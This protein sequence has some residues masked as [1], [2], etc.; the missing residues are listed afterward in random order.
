VIDLVARLGAIP[1]MR[2]LI[3]GL[4]LPLPLPFPLRRSDAAW[5]PRP[6]DD[7]AV[8]FG[9]APGGALARVVARTLVMAGASP[10]VVASANANGASADARAF[11]ELGEAHGRPPVALDVTAPPAGFRARG[12][13]F[14]AT[15]VEDPLA[16][17][18]LHAFFHPLLPSLEASGRV[19]VLG[20]PAA[21]ALS[22]LQAAARTAL[23]GFVRSLA[24]EVGRR[25]ATAQLVVVHP[26][27]EARLEPVLRFILSPRAAFVSGQSLSV[28][29][30]V[31]VTWTTSSSSSSSSSSFDPPFV[32][33][34]EG[35]VALVTG[36]ARGIGE[37]TARCLAREGARVVCLDR[38]ADDA[39]A[40]EVAHD[41][42]GELLALDLGAADAPAAIT[43]HLRARH[44]GLDVL[45][46]NAG[47]T[48]DRTLA[49]M[50]AEQWS[51]VLDVNLMAMARV[52]GALD[53]AGL[54]REGGRVI[55]LSSVSGIAGNLGQTN[56]AASKA[57]VIG[58][59]RKRAEALAARG[60]TANAVAPGFIETR[61]TAAMPALVR[62]AGRRLSALGQG[63]LPSDVAEVI[64]FLATPGAAGV[65]GAVL[66]VCGGALMGA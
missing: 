22:P 9:A 47:V 13:V 41:V 21:R 20:R 66:R 31:T 51:A 28:D 2:R 10:H 60:I 33:P 29:C 37:A 56:Y 58:Y 34:L 64:T 26:D 17:A 23:D 5:E 46:H 25:G 54:L 32:R 38:P 27:A 45:V 53:A 57:G 3:R 1:A 40:A 11:R 63:G 42:G 16:L 44:G 55:A 52:D 36:A 43:R 30:T 7:C 15:G 14:D 35:K 62:E 6:L 4:R 65:T 61:L 24:K 49:R 18:A 39:R 12:L 8:A 48:R 50:T 59:V 19:V